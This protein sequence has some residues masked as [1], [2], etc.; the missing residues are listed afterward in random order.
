MDLPP[1]PVFQDVI[2]KNII[3]QVPLAQLISKYDGVTFQEARGMIRRYKVLRLP[4]F[5]ILHYRRFTKNNFVE[6]RNPTIVNFPVRGLDM[7]ETVEGEQDANISTAY[8]LVANITHEATAGTVKDNQV[9]RV[10]VHT[11]L[12]GEPVHQDGVQPGKGKAAANGKSNGKAHDEEDSGEASAAEEEKWYQIQDLF[13]EE[14][15]RQMLFLGETYIQIWERKDGSGEVS[16][17]MR[18]IAAKQAE[19]PKAKGKAQLKTQLK[20]VQRT[21]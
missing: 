8:D 4:P 5:V 17:L 1:P 3:P 7:E 13:V 14:I 11:R 16:E 15:N 20:P 10:Q 2:E 18:R 21:M 19:D 6:E 12:D 9:W